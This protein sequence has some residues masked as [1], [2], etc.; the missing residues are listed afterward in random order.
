MSNRVP[1]LAF[2]ASNELF[3]TSQKTKPI[4]RGS[5][6]QSPDQS[7]RTL[8]YPMGFLLVKLAHRRVSVV[9][10]CCLCRCRILGPLF[11][12]FTFSIVCTSQ[13]A[14]STEQRESNKDKAT[15][16]MMRI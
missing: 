14:W 3:Y 7:C 10:A 6:V 13:M 2:L 1:I 8:L 16:G 4:G 11:F 15:K 5:E 12:P 9:S